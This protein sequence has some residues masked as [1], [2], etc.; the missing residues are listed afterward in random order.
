MQLKPGCAMR[1]NLPN[2]AAPNKGHSCGHKVE[3]R[4]SRTS[5][6]IAANIQQMRQFRHP[7]VNRLH[8]QY[9]PKPY[10]PV[11]QRGTRALHPL[12][13]FNLC[14]IHARITEPHL[15]SGQL[16]KSFLSPS[17]CKPLLPK[18]VPVALSVP[19]YWRRGRRPLRLYIFL[20]RPCCKYEGNSLHVT[21]T[22]NAQT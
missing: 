14:V 16:L 9:K 18:H 15:G 20:P 1:W 11:W 19:S 3:S 17:T 4:S 2:C 5:H 6:R 22:V 8:R 10:V 12:D 13:H 7:T 21:S